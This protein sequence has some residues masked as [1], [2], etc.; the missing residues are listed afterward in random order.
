MR[1]RNLGFFIVLLAAILAATYFAWRTNTPTN[2]RAHQEITLRLDS[3][4]LNLYPPSLSE[5]NSRRIGTLLHE[6]LIRTNEKAEL[7]PGIA[8]SWRHDGSNWRFF[9]PS[10]RKFSNGDTVTPADVAASICRSMQPSSAWGWALASIR[11]TQHGNRVKCDGISIAGNEIEISQS[12][13]APWLM[14]ALSGPAGWVLPA[15]ADSSGRYGDAPGAGRYRVAEIVPDSYVLLQPVNPN[16]GPP[17]VRFIYVPD[18]IQAASLLKDGQLALL[19]LQSPTLRQLVS[20]ASG[21]MGESSNHYLSTHSFDRVRVLILNEE[22]LAQLGLS[23]TDIIAFRNALDTSIDRKK[24]ETISDG[25]AVA[26]ARVLPIFGSLAR[27]APAQRDVA[28]LPQ[29]NITVVTEPDSFSDQ[30]A[31]ALP[32]RIGN[33]TLSHKTLEKGLLINSIIKENFDIASV[34][35]E[36]TI[37]SPKF[38]TAFFDPS[39]AFV[40]FGKPIPGVEKIDVSDANALRSL[41]ALLSAQSNW[42]SLLRENRVDAQQKWLIGLHYSSSGQDD[43]SNIRI[44]ATTR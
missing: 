11:S 16:A 40:A 34:V 26:D 24:L 1:L 25:L 7:E 42:I 29:I 31:A 8:S 37:H 13:N 38:W 4:A 21:V 35:I 18:D 33:I 10:D 23:P 12:F 20:G 41:E 27:S 15:K 9:I 17:P 14:E 44:Q 39:G 32:T 28:A 36:A 5:T 30:I 6:P 3:F 43:L 22:R 19:Y 2:Q